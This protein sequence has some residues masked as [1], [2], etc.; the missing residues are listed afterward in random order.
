MNKPVFAALVIMLTVFLVVPVRAEVSVTVR[1]DNNLSV[2]YEFRNLDQS[3]YDDAKARFAAD[4]I[5]KI[6]VANMANENR[7]VEYGVTDATYFDDATRTIRNSFTLSGSGIISSSLN[8]TDLK[9]VYEVRTDWRRFKVDLTG[10]FSYDFNNYAATPVAEWQKPNAT[11]FYLE[12]R[13]TGTLD[14]QF[15]IVLPASASEVHAVSDTISYEMPGSSVDQFLYSPF[16]ILIGLAVVLVIVLLYR[17][18]R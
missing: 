16:P 6:I 15:Y 13:A 2:I 3:V 14:L 1:V 9:Q 10:S 17:R 11:T 18:L 7:T 4:T 8:K 12:N 5:P